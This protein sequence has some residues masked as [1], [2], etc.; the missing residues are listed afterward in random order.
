MGSSHERSRKILKTLDFCAAEARRSAGPYRASGP[1]QLVNV[2]TKADILVGGTLDDEADCKERR[3]TV[4]VSRR[5]GVQPFRSAEGTA[6]SRSGQQ[7]GMAD[8]GKKA[9]YARS[10]KSLQ[11]SATQA[12]PAMAASYTL[13]GAII[14]LGGLGYVVDRWR[15]TAPWFLVTGLVVGVVIGFYELIK[16][17][18]RK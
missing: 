8:K 7:G 14:V 3:S 1:F 6:F 9:S 17:A 13:V 18:Y 15:G 4:P 10:A 16:T 2:F 11:E 5:N 12:G